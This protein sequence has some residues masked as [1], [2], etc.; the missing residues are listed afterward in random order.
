M[1][2][3]ADVGSLAA[4]A[5]VGAMEPPIPYNTRECGCGNPFSVEFLWW[6]QR[7]PADLQAPHSTTG[8]VETNPGPPVIH[9]IIAPEIYPART[10]RPSLLTARNGFTDSAQT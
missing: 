4:A 9:P 1:F 2:L 3:S 10:W 7:T 5:D 8:D 6:R